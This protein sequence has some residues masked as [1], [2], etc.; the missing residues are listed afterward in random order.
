MGGT[1]PQLISLHRFPGPNAPSA[2]LEGTQCPLAH[3]RLLTQLPPL[4]PDG[5]EL[6]PQ[7]LHVQ[8]QPA[9]SFA[10]WGETQGAQEGMRVPLWWGRGSPNPPRAPLCQGA[11]PTRADPVGHSGFLKPCAAQLLIQVLQ[12][13][14]G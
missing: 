6:L 10:C 9:G 1:S 2:R 12:E 14:E 4:A 11:A 3:A 5:K 7:H 8:I 13:L